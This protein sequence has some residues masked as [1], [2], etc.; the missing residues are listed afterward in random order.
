M[1]SIG[2]TPIGLL[3]QDYQIITI[4]DQAHSREVIMDYGAHLLVC[5]YYLP[6]RKKAFPFCQGWMSLFFPLGA[7]IQ[8]QVTDLPYSTMEWQ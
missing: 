3:W 5:V 1:P 4:H 8:L 2:P 7:G 6:Y